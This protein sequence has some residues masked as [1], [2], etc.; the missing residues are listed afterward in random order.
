[1]ATPQCEHCLNSV[2]VHCADFGPLLAHGNL[3][4]KPGFA[5][6]VKTL[7]GWMIQGG[8]QQAKRRR[9][10]QVHSPHARRG[11][12]GKWVQIDDSHH[13]WFWC[14]SGKYWLTAFIEGATGRVLGAEF[15]EHETTQGK[16]S[17]LHGLVQGHGAPPALYSD[18]PGIFTK[19]APDDS[20]PTR[21]EGA[22]L[23]LNI[24]L[25]CAHSPQAKGRIDRLFQTL[26]D[27]MCKAMRLAGIDTT[28]QANSW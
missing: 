3:Q 5:W 1:M 10:Q 24:G 23:Q 18:R 2:R 28:E 15:F 21:V 13:D 6:R 19:H 8:L 9:A 12:P 22:L 27:R 4:R 20:K 25:I 26:Q 11:C 7:R 16:L 14:R 17:V